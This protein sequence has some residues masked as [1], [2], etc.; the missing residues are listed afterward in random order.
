M[1]Q[2]VPSSSPTSQTVTVDSGRDGF[3]LGSPPTRPPGGGG[4]G[5]GGNGG[6][7]HSF[8]GEGHSLGGILLGSRATGAMGG[9][10]TFRHLAACSYTSPLRPSPVS[11][12]TSLK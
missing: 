8:P 1:Q 9:A 7:D 6:G 11:V 10:H 2:Q 5:G 3:V 4:S 12:V